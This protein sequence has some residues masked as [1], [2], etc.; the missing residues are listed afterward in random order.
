MASGSDGLADASGLRC[1]DADA[2][3]DWLG[4]LCN[5]ERLGAG[6]GPLQAI[7]HSASAATA[8]TVRGGRI[9]DPIILRLRRRHAPRFRRQGTHGRRVNG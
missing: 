2:G 8:A 3:P 5:A 4:P 9:G 1:G 7:A 6:E